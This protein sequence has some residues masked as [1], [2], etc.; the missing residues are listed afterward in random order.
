[1]LYLIILKSLL[2]LATSHPKPDR[3][4]QPGLTGCGV[5]GDF[6]VTLKGCHVLSLLQ[7]QSTLQ[8][9]HWKEE[10]QQLATSSP[11]PADRV[12]TPWPSTQG[13]PSTLGSVLSAYAPTTWPPVVTCEIETK[14]KALRPAEHQRSL[15]KPV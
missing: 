8:G 5:D 9:K 11:C 15:S 4:S 6:S 10:T 14:Q 2:H 1:M 7:E 13:L 3:N 12:R